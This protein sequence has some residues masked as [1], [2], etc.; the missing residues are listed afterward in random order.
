MHVFFS[1]CAYVEAHHKRKETPCYVYYLQGE[2]WDEQLC[3]TSAQAATSFAT[4][5]GDKCD[6]DAVQAAVVSTEPPRLEDVPAHIAFCK[7]WGGGNKQELMAQ[8]MDYIQQAMPVGRIVS[9]RFL[10]KLCSLKF[11]PSE[12]PPLTIHALVMAQSVLP[13]DRESIGV[14]VSDAHVR[15]LTTTNK[16]KGKQ[17]DAMLQNAK[18]LLALQPEADPLLFGNFAVELV[19]NM[20]EL[21]SEFKTL[22]DVSAHFATLMVSPTMSTT[23]PETQA[24][25]EEAAPSGSGFVAFTA[26]GVNNA[27]RITVCNRGFSVGEHIEHKTTASRLQ[28]KQF[29]IDYINDDGS[30]GVFEALMDGTFATAITVLSMN[31]LLLDY[32]LAK[33]PIKLFKNYPQTSASHCQDLIN[34]S[35]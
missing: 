34:V 9:G 32:K 4:S 10:S 15:S 12:L 7:I 13:K 27:G 20:F 26:S 35:L 6:W 2:S 11:H 31:T 16:A 17:I 18:E 21:D 22:E 30:V 23:A 28:A 24:P 14:S 5:R 33:S 8:T 3:Y 19:K 1:K 29:K 25:Q